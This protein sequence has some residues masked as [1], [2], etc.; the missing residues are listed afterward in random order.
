ILMSFVTAVFGTR[1]LLNMWFKCVYL[2]DCKT[3]LGVKLKKIQDIKEGG[4]VAPTYVNCSI[5]I[6]KHQ[7]KIFILTIRMLVID[8]DSLV[9]FQ[10]NPGIDFSSG[11]SVEILADESLTTE[12]IESDLESLDLEAKSIVLSGENEEN[13]VSRFDTVLEKEKINEIKNLFNDKYG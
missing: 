12:E 13:A 5:N 4:E 9:I 1:V 6:I 7:K 3:W 8:A 10:L 11:S 2:K